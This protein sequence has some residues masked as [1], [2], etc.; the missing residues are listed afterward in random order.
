MHQ[1]T[2]LCKPTAAGDDD[3]DDREEEDYKD[4]DNYNEDNEFMF[5]D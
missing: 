2:Q 5:K 1:H 3:G 4:S